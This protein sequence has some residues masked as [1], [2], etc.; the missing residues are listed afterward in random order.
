MV[1]VKEG[2]DP[3]QPKRNPICQLAQSETGKEVHRGG[4]FVTL[5]TVVEALFVMT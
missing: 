1:F 2:V 4:S 5:A 3:W